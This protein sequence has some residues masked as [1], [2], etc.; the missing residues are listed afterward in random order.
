MKLALSRYWHTVR[1]LRPV[2]F[3]GRIWFRFH[4]PQFNF[5]EAPD[6]RRIEAAWAPPARRRPSLIEPL[7][8]SFLNEE[9]HLADIGWDSP[10][11]EKLWCYNL[12]Y[13]DDLNAEEAN[14]R[15]DWHR[16]LLVSWVTDN[17][18]A[19]GGTGWEPYPT[20][21]RVVNWIKW[22][23][24]GNSLEPQ[25]LHSLAV[26]TRLL[27]HR[28]E[29]HLL[30]NH[31]FANAK[32]LVF[33]GLFFCGPEAEQWLATG[34]R[35]L[36]REIPEQILSD[37][38]QFERSTMYHALTL[39]DLL[40]LLNVTRTFLTAVSPR[41]ASVV[42]NL[43]EPI[44]RMRH[45]LATMCHPDGEISFFN[46]AAVGIAPPPAS[47]EAYARRLGLAAVPEITD[48]VVH[49][50]DSGYIRVRQ[51]QVSAL[52]DVAWIGPDYLP[53]H[54]HADTLSF[55]LSLFGQRLFVNS[56]T[57][58]YGRSPERLRQ[59][60]TAAHNTVLVDGKDSSEVWGGFRVARR[61][62]PIDLR[63]SA[64]DEPVT[65]SCSHDGYQRLARECNHRR[66][67]QF[68][69]NELVITDT[70]SGSV[71]HVQARFHLHPSVRVSE[72]RVD[73]AQ[74]ETVV[75]QLSSNHDVLLWVQ[76][77]AIRTEASTWHP[78][79]GCSE[80]NLCLV[81]DVGRLPLVT[82]LLWESKP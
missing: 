81:V 22:A 37:G 1:H 53:G 7:R 60:G 31:L 8:F 76:G 69:M 62:K 52:L 49:L 70:V 46:D 6:L 11:V 65:V 79:F 48:N 12:H 47:L 34:F 33:S 42:N 78:E 14:C 26:Q 4:K 82:R 40:D 24:A 61:A 20:S 29:V 58:C 63:I 35:Y 75:L 50:A 51:G 71:R 55:E 59:R 72:K 10:D 74:N 5:A 28:M 9:H 23:L 15:A 68:F 64:A 3:Y 19:K 67:W 32:A 39:E 36:E 30:G 66:T 38:G 77:G 16:K 21:L 45:W 2:Q 54:A 73:A 80:P 17:P 56:G 44:Q 18:P 13:F 43:T 57:S 25:C 41:W 27:F